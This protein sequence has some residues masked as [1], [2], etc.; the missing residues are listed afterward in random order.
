MSTPIRIPDHIYTDFK[1]L[2][3]DKS[4]SIQDIVTIALQNYL[5]NQKPK[6]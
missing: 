4:M 1:W 2:A 5:N 6:G 3:K